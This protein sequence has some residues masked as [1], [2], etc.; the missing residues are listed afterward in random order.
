MLHCT[1]AGALGGSLPNWLFYPL[2]IA[3][4]FW[5]FS[6]PFVTLG[7][8]AVATWQRREPAAQLALLET[9]LT[10]VVSL[11]YFYQAARFMAPPAMMLVVWCAV[12]LARLIASCSPRSLRPTVGERQ[13]IPE[14]N[15]SIP[16]LTDHGPRRWR[17]F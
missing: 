12:G 11:P 5:I 7:G 15:S 3:G 2:V 17:M 14:Q 13:P 4:A 1:E 16:L 10:I 8:L 9:I 6:L